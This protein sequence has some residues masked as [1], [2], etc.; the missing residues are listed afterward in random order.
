VLLCVRL[1]SNNTTAFACSAL[2]G[3]GSVLGVLLPAAALVTAALSAIIY[4]G[5]SVLAGYAVLVVGWLPAAPL[6]F[7][8]RA[9]Q[10]RTLWTTFIILTCFMFF[11]SFSLAATGALY[12]LPAGEVA[13]EAC[14]YVGKNPAGSLA[15]L[16]EVVCERSGGNLSASSACEPWPSDLVR[17]NTRLSYL[18]SWFAG[19]QL[20]VTYNAH[21]HVFIISVTPSS[22]VL[23]FMWTQPT[24]GE[25][26]QLS[27]MVVSILVLAAC[28]LLAYVVIPPQLLMRTW[29]R[30]SLFRE[31]RACA[32]QVRS[33]RGSSTDLSVLALAEQ[34]RLIDGI[35]RATGFVAF[36]PHLD[37]V[38]PRVAYWPQLRP[39]CQSISKLREAILYAA[40]VA[41]ENRRVAAA[42][43]GVGDPEASQAPAQKQTQRAEPPPQ[44]QLAQAETAQSSAHSVAMTTAEQ[45]VAVLSVP[46]QR[47]A[48]SLAALEVAEQLTLALADCVALRPGSGTCEEFQRERVQGL[49]YKL[50]M[51]LVARL[52]LE[53]GA[54]AGADPAVPAA[55][56]ASPSQYAQ[57]RVDPDMM[58][59]AIIA[60][61]LLTLKAEV[62][63]LLVMQS[64]PSYK[65]LLTTVLGACGSFLLFYV[66]LAESAASLCAKNKQGPVPPAQKQSRDNGSRRRWRQ[67]WGP[68]TSYSVRLVLAAAG[69]TAVV[70]FAPG[71]NN[72]MLYPVG[73]TP[74]S[75]VIGGWV[76]LPVTTCTGLTTEGTTRMTHMRLLGTG[77]GALLGW[78]SALA[79]YSS[80]AGGAVLV[81]VLATLC[82]FVGANEDKSPFSYFRYS[83]GYH[84]QLASWTVVVI[85]LDSFST[86]SKPGDSSSLCKY[87]VGQIA[88][89]RVIAMLVGVGIVFFVAVLVLPVSGTTASRE[90]LA[91]AAHT[92]ADAVEAG[93]AAQ[94]AAAT[95]PRIAAA[96]ELFKPTTL[97]AELPLPLLAA[98]LAIPRLTD[99]VQ[100]LC[101]LAAALAMARAR[102]LKQD[103]QISQQE[104][105][106]LEEVVDRAEAL[107]RAV[108]SCVAECYHHS[109]AGRRRTN[110]RH[111]NMCG[112]L[113]DDWGAALLEL[114][115]ALAGLQPVAQVDPAKVLGWEHPLRHARTASRRLLFSVA[116]GDRDLRGLD[117]ERTAPAAQAASTASKGSAK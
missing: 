43:P 11:S 57:V 6:A 105:Q 18:D 42:R 98:D 10:T 35:T 79:L 32:G 1:V 68:S 22:W 108:A 15:Q 47:S 5:G 2:Y 99:L 66:A 109:A 44:Q 54:G 74:W 115:Q 82:V 107:L 77:V 97:F 63:T 100:E 28:M 56:A 106:Q 110:C 29:V 81:A 92:C 8:P 55:P 70:L 41:E 76:I 37:E 103:A 89:L 65:G 84:Y 101:L 60:H 48:R 40:V 13:G 96:Q 67:M 116:R 111:Y 80:I 93:E 90:E 117:S 58:E 95:A 59:V 112:R 69:L 53:S 9:P 19:E 91:E 23:R 34:T 3:G 52:Q 12:G 25:A 94:I 72:Y 21:S 33:L 71:V 62:D 45:P 46:V 78:I 104:Q 75:G 88:A 31:L 86:C 49:S 50:A 27:S 24:A 87:T 4:S 17:N 39:V 102:G 85:A 113:T 26:S 73:A 38:G 61:G 7:G 64:T 36:E 51:D 114:D 16:A 83:D 14:A 20:C 30:E